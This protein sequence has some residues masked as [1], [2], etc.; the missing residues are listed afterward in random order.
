[1]G[2][3]LIG[4]EKGKFRRNLESRFAD[5][6]G[7]PGKQTETDRGG[8]PGGVVPAPSFHA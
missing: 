5:C 1:M 7:L 8:S 3:Q 2:D 4:E 6:R